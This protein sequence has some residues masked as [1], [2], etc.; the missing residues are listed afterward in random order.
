[1]R[2]K[3][4]CGSIASGLIVLFLIASLT[5]CAPVQTVP[6]FSPCR[7]PLIDPTSNGGLSRAVSS[8][9]QEVDSCNAR[10]GV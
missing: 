6:E 9:V 10:N 4:H 1:M 3:N 2:L 8:Y 7:H 5:A